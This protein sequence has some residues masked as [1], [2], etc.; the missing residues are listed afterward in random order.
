M[1]KGSRLD[2]GGRIVAFYMGTG[3][4]DRGRALP[5]V[6]RFSL[7]ELEDNHD[8]IQWL[9]PL[10]VPSGVQPLAPLVDDNCRQAF[11]RSPQLRDALRRALRRML[12]F[13]GLRIVERADPA[14]IERGPSW[15]T[16]SPN[17][18]NP[19]NHNYL[20]VTR[21]MTS[22]NLL[23]EKELAI[24]L[25]S[26]LELIYDESPSLIGRTTIEYWRRAIS[27]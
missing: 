12:E 7:D 13:Y 20:R 10:D 26:C 11:R 1:S 21:I 8:Y 5:E 3:V 9:F 14:V 23:G 27:A 4:D 17:W 19:G 25:Q 15:S 18:L 16:R 2:G 24:A 22:L 6:M